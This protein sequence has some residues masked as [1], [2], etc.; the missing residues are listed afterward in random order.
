MVYPSITEGTSISS[1]DDIFGLTWTLQRWRICISWTINFLMIVI[2]LYIAVSPSQSPNFCYR[3]SGLPRHLVKL[4]AR[5][6][7]FSAQ[8]CSI[9]FLC[10]PNI[11]HLVRIKITICLCRSRSF[12]GNDASGNQSGNIHF[13]ISPHYLLINMNLT[14]HSSLSVVTHTNTSHHHSHRV[15]ERSTYQTIC[16]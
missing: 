1:A 13:Y 2:P 14:V 15:L 16:Y 6:T 9:R 8:A 10:T 7:D 3:S 4:L 12:I 5:L 11:R